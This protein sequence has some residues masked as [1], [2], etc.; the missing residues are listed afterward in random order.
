MAMVLL[1]DASAK[2]APAFNGM[3]YTAFGPANVLA[4]A[5]SNAS[6]L[7]MRQIGTDTVAINTRWFQSAYNSNSVQE[8]DNRF[9]ATMSSIASA[10]DYV[11]NTLGMK[12]LLKPMLDVDDGNWRAYISPTNPDAWFGYTAANPFVSGSSTH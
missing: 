2:A 12:V 9:S 3:S 4:T 5:G 8:E 7:K 10:I 11:H 1:A 6:L